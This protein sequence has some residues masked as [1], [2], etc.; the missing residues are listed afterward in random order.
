MIKMTVENIT[1]QD[2][3]KFLNT[4]TIPDVGDEIELPCGVKVICTSARGDKFISNPVFHFLVESLT[5]I[6]INLLSAYI[7]TK[8]FETKKDAKL[9]I[10]NINVKTDEESIN[11]KLSRENE[12][13]D[14]EQE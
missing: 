11:A 6:S 14:C 13:E 5:S 9:R 8:I 7:Y 2:F 3:L 10:N 12:G 1:E 4:N